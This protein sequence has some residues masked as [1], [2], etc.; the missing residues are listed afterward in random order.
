MKKFTQAEYLDALEH[1][2]WLAA[3]PDAARKQLV[4]R[5]AAKYAKAGTSPL[6][7]KGMRLGAL[8]LC[9][10][11]GVVHFD[12]EMVEYDDEGDAGPYSALIAQLAEGSFGMFKPTKIKDALDG[13]VARVSFML[14]KKK[15]S[16][17]LQLHRDWFEPDA[18]D[19][20]VNEALRDTGVSFRFR[21]LPTT[22]QCVN[23]AFIPDEVWRKTIEAGI[24][25]ADH[26]APVRDHKPCREDQLAGVREWASEI[27]DALIKQTREQGR[28]RVAV[29]GLG[30][31]GVRPARVPG[32]YQLDFHAAQMLKNVANGQL[33]EPEPEESADDVVTAIAALMRAQYDEFALPGIGRLR[34]RAMPAY[35]GRNP[36]SGEAVAIGAKNMVTLDFDPALLTDLKKPAKRYRS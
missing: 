28:A 1:A 12:A 24:V 14:G 4:E 7:P 10:V 29:A 32:E 26:V 23:L 2:G 16:I 21:A 33:A 34:V 25:P 13:R 22:D 11:L 6:A 30:K 19:I 9:E 27:R 31:I 20:L 3:V 15:F 36:L 18:I 35:E 17:E 5:I 8:D